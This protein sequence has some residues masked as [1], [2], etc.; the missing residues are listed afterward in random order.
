MPETEQHGE[1]FCKSKLPPLNREQL[2]SI[3][4]IA[5]DE[6][7]MQG[8]VLMENAGCGAAGMINLHAPLGK[9]VILCGGGNNGGDGYVIARHLQRYN[10]SVK[11]LSLVDKTKITGDAS[12]NYQIAAKADIPHHFIETPKQIREH[13]S[14]SGVIIDSMLGT[15]AKGPPKRL[16]SDAIQ[17]ANV[18]SA[19]RFAIDLPTGLDCDSG[20][21]SETTF[22]ADHTITF[23]AEKIGFKKNNADSFVGAVHVVDIGVPQN[24]LKH[25]LVSGDSRR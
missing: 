9:I 1:R 25:F 6:Y 7:Q 11:T 5:I 24:L 4:R 17:E 8:I 10:R 12:V 16:F 21:A 3:D 18:S 15:G 14:E 20:I 22:R 2:R 13:L 23:V 19:T